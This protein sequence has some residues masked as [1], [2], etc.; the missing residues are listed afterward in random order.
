MKPA[1]EIFVAGVGVNSALGLNLAANLHALQAGSSGI[2]PITYL[3]TKHREVFSVG[4]VKSSNIDLGLLTGLSPDTSRTALLSYIAAREAWDDAGLHHETGLRIGFVSA[5]SVG[6]MDKSEDFFE[7]WMADNKKGKLKNVVGHECGYITDLVAMK[8]GIHHYT[9]TISTACSSSANA[10]FHAARMITAGYLDVAIAGGAEALTRFT[11]NGLNSLMIL[12]P[13]PCKPLDENRKGLN[14][15]EGAGYIVLAS[16]KAMSQ[17]ETKA[18][19]R[20]SGWHNVNDAFHQTTSSPEGFG[21]FM[22]MQ[23]AIRKSGIRQEEIGYINV[24]GTSTQ[25]NDLS[26]GTALIRLFGDALPKLSST[27]AY[28]GHTLGASGGIEAVFSVM[29]IAHGYVYPNLR[30]ETPMKDAP[31]LPETSFSIDHNLRHVLSNSFG[32]GGN[33]STLIFSAA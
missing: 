28:T 23:G 33:C 5:N 27:K 2:G 1:A 24:H 25:N 19:C 13:L 9:S 29:S 30:F 21:S 32:F 22:S 31:L 14:L 17:L 16:A 26:E 11:L 12:D 7:E 20:L 3:N 4:E 15:G 6:G 10:I 8:L 18:Y